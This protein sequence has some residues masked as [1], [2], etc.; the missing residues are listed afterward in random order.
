[1]KRPHAGILPGLGACAAVA[2]ASL[3]A[4]V[5]APSAAQ[6][7]AG[8]SAASAP[9]SGASAA[10]RAGR[11]A[12][13]LELAATEYALGVPDEGGQ[14]TSR[15]EF[16]EARGFIGQARE[17]F[18]DLPAPG[19]GA[20]AR[21]A[22]E[23]ASAR[24]DSLTSLLDARAAPSDVH[25]LASRAGRDLARA[26]GAVLVPEPAR[27]PSAARGAAL[28]RAGCAECHGA[29]GRGDGPAGAGIEPPPA[30]FTRPARAEEGT[31]ARDFQVVTLGVPGTLM[32]GRGDELSV[33]Q[34]W[35][36]VS[37]LQTLRFGAA[38]VA[39]GKDLALGDSAGG[40]P[41]ASELR[42]W[43]SLP[44]AARLSDADLGRRIQRLWSDARGDT[45]PE[46]EVRAVVAYARTLLG[47]PASGLP[48]P[49]RGRALAES[50][51][52]A[53]SLAG[54]A[55]GLG[56]A[57]DAGSARAAAV[58]AY[59]AFEGVETQLR[60]RAP[61]LTSRIEV[62]F[63]GLRDAAAS[64]GE[65]G[66]GGEQPSV[67]AARREVHDLLG[68]A[69]EELT[70]PVTAWSL[71]TQSFFVILREGFEAILII[72]AIL[73]FLAKTGAEERKRDVHLGAGAAVVASFLTAWALQELLQ[74]TP[75]SQDVLEGA[76]M[77][78]AV[79]VLFSVSYWLLSRMEHERWQ[80][81]LRSRMQ[82]A[83]GAGGGLALASVAFLA[84]YRE[85]F[86]TV[87]F[88]K[89]LFGF[90]SGGVGPV[91]GGFLAGCVALAA[92][93]MAF[94][95]FGVR[96]PMRPFFGV[97][98]GVLYYMAVVF[99]GKGIHELQ[100]AGVV[101]STHLAGMPRIELLG[102]YPDLQSLLAQ[103]VLLALLLTALWLTFGRGSGR[104]AGT[105][106]PEGDA[107]RQEPEGPRAE[108]GAGARAG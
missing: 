6:P 45:L 33:E 64:S 7:A 105:E 27:R 16:D 19:E 88:Y 53:D 92:I 50:I 102:I 23:R 49:D 37:Y 41:V 57:G 99:V 76:T 24:L 12:S 96:I 81:Y 38:D 8:A 18:S 65:A 60:S 26:W 51:E 30:D 68:Q 39:E 25:A 20:D 89:A 35:D 44:S 48:A 40:S 47:T 73:T 34:R 63:A 104:T 100:E 71:A 107:V 9:T 106:E 54:V 67:D 43:S 15:A 69:R 97:T 4:A 13:L 21:A 79:V 98:S 78:V 103:V 11:V 61:D 17:L 31:P 55:A 3:A 56:R 5:P 75:A 59:M 93:Y 83:L 74:V 95:R 91:V 36:L 94:N 70:S 1:M 46:G 29:G 84:V 82:K 87:L 22:A 77:L 10:E 72:G 86:E 80:R 52:R 108:A 28:Y 58:D 14:I 66:A 101:P 32:K 90:S 62:A 85:G 2:L 42:G